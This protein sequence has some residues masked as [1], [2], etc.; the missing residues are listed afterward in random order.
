MW[1]LNER[2][3]E[4]FMFYP[5][6]SENNRPADGDE[7]EDQDERTPSNDGFHPM[8]ATE[9]DLRPANCS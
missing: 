3:G 4:P 6:F 8:P 1:Q 2:E 9:S 5:L 7:I